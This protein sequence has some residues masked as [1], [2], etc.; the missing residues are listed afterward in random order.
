MPNIDLYVVKRIKNLKRLSVLMNVNECN[1]VFTV[2]FTKDVSCL[3]FIVNTVNTWS[4][5]FMVR[6]YQFNAK[7]IFIV[8]PRVF[9]GLGKYIDRST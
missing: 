1:G 6:I 2:R 4:T 5:Q 3:L 8:W 7:I 9:L